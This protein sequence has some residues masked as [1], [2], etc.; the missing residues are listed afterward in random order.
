KN[1]YKRVLE[2]AGVTYSVKNIAELLKMKY[3]SST[4]YQEFIN[5]VD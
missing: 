5:F 2:A 3:R 4:I 1:R